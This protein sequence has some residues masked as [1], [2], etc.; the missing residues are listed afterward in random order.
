MSFTERYY[1]VLLME[2]AAEIIHAASKGWRFGLDHDEPGYGQGTNK[3]QITHEVGDLLAIIEK[4]MLDPE[5]INK[6]KA[7]KHIKLQRIEQKYTVSKEE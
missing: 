6:A 3:D 7:R 5:E 1:L 2:E 4:L